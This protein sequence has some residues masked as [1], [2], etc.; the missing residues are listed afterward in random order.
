MCKYFSKTMNKWHKSFGRYLRIY[1]SSFLYYACVCFKRRNDICT[2]IFWQ[3][4]WQLS[5]TYSHYVFTFSLNC[6][7]FCVNTWF[8]K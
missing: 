1:F 7:G 2:I 5:L 4:L 3:L 8:F 6:F